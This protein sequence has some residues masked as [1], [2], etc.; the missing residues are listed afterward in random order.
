MEI[1]VLGCHGAEMP[2]YRTTCFM[3]NET[4]LVDAGSITSVLELG[5]QK[6]IKDILVT[7]SHL[8]H[9]KDIPLFAD[10]IVGTLESH[11]NVISSKEVISVLKNHLFNNI[12]WP[13]FSRIPTPEKPVINFIEIE[14]G[15]P[16]KVNGLTV[17]A[18]EVN[19]PVPTL[20]YI[21]SDDDG[22]MAILGDTGPTTEIWK[23]IGETK[24]MKGVFIETSFPNSMGDLAELSGHLTPDMLEKEIAKLNGSKIPV[25]VYHMKPN[26]LGTLE[27]EISDL[28]NESI[29]MLSLDQSLQF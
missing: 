11:V 7:H 6:A 29:S 25:Y 17:L 14:P 3:I 4:T 28:K 9:I 20:G 24:N 19:H 21:L 10:N 12:I 26:F 23:T 1:R 13:D 2:G 8:D 5:E 27:S 22:S 15:I 18:V 16:F